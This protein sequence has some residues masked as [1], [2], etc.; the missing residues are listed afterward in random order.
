MA[1]KNTD[2]MER[3]GDPPPSGPVSDAVAELDGAA[4]GETRTVTVKK[5][6]EEKRADFTRLASRRV[7]NALDALSSLRH[8][9]SPS[10]YEWDVEQQEKIFT[11][12]QRSL[13]DLEAAFTN[14]K[15]AQMSGQKTPRA[16]SFN[17]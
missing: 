4:V 9:A 14:A 11:T 8:L 6:I 2:V 3:I 7:S 15:A 17:L 16:L 12:L 1:R 13:H 10:S 5:T